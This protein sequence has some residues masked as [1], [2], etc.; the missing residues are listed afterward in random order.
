MALL[1]GLHEGAG[2]GGASAGHEPQRGE[3]D[4]V[5]VL[6]GV[7]QDVVP[8][9]RHGPRHRRLLGHDQLDERLALEEPGRHHE[10]GAGHPAGVGEPP[11]VG[12][13]HRDDRQDAVPLGQPERRPAGGGH[14]VQERGAVAV[15]D[16]L[17]VA[18]RAAR[19]AHGRRRPLVDLGVVEAARLGG[20]Q[21]LV[22]QDVGTQG[23]GVALADDHEVLD[24]LE[25]GRHPGQEGDEGGVD[26]D[27]PVLGVVGDV[28]QLLGEQPE[29]QRVEHGA[30]RG[31]GQV[32]LEVL[33][34]VPGEGGDPVALPDA[35][36]GQGRG[37]PVGP[38][39]H[40][41]EAGPPA[42]LALER[43]HL[44]PAEHAPAVPEDRRDGE[45]E[46]L[47]RREHSGGTSSGPQR[48][49]RDER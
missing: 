32:G 28:G 8:D 41:G 6:V 36:A 35:E 31:D 22:G 37:Q 43:H 26:E 47:H 18:G 48:P 7:G 23:A 10:V 17:R 46:V 38:V 34:G 4:G 3:V 40:L 27:H 44:A 13:E 33:L 14:R 29:V 39:G 9:G 1:E 19:V 49:N 30:H 42:R 45:R 11:G 16:A 24:G 12:V 25:L 20:Q 15:D 5:L 2:D 21:L